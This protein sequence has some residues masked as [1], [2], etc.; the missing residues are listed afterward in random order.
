MHSSIQRRSPKEVVDA[1]AA[2]AIVSEV[3]VML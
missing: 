3:I 2:K 1:T